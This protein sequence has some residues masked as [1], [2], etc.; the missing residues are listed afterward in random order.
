MNIRDF[1]KLPV[2]EKEL[3][4]CLTL[5][6]KDLPGLTSEQWSA[7]LAGIVQCTNLHSLILKNMDLSRLSP[8]RWS[9]L[10]TCISQCPNLNLTWI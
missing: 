1:L 8:E 4:E 10:L 9:M 5:N 7:L 2:H 3:L 6:D